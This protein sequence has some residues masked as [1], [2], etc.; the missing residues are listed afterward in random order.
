MLRLIRL[1]N[2]NHMG[3]II[4]GGGRHYVEEF[5]G[6]FFKT[7]H[8]RFTTRRPLLWIYHV[9]NDLSCSYQSSLVTWR[10]WYRNLSVNMQLLT[11]YYQE[12]IQILTGL[13][14]LQLFLELG[15]LVFKALDLLFHLIKL[16]RMFTVSFIKLVPC[17]KSFIKMLGNF[18]IFLIQ[19][20]PIIY[21]LIQSLGF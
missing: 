18:S 17:S 19:G 11:R 1:D 13:G 8:Q 9:Y 5:L 3:Q 20:V 4:L 2:S 10:T 15:F 21:G 6:S 7:L 16:S 14:S 12:K